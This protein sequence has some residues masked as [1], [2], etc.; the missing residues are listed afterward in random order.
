[1]D[2]KGEKRLCELQI[3]RQLITIHFKNL[4]KLILSHMFLRGRRTTAG[5]AVHKVRTMRGMKTRSLRDECCLSAFQ[6]GGT[7]ML[8]SY[9]SKKWK[10]VPWVKTDR[11]RQTERFNFQTDTVRRREKS[12]R[13]SSAN[14]VIFNRISI[15]TFFLFYLPFIYFL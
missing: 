7:E 10:P 4:Q 12:D 13:Q 2:S 11:R 5:K 1:M 8:P 15:R 3:I 14:L 6:L 9:W